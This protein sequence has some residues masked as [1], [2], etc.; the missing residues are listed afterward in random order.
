MAGWLRDPIVRVA[1]F[2]FGF[3]LSGCGKSGPCVHVYRDALVHVTAVVDSASGGA[4]DSVFITNVSVNGDSLPLHLAVF[5]SGH[6][7]GVLV[8]GDTVRCG[9]PSAFGTNEGHWEVTLHARGFTSQTV[10][11]D[12][13]YREGK[14]GCPS[15]DDGGISVVWTLSRMSP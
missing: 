14:G 5:G 13:R 11:F 8:D 6:E 7:I 2:L 15:Y 3:G 12:A 9:V 1:V 10:R 4:I